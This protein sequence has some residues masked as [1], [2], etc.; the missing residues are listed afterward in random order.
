MLYRFWR[1]EE[2]VVRP[3]GL[4]ST[5]WSDEAKDHPGF[6]RRLEKLRAGWTQMAGGEK[7]PEVKILSRGGFVTMIGREVPQREDDRPP[8]PPHVPKYSV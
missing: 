4:H 5:V 8:L 6:Q 7:I 2:I 1:A 3:G